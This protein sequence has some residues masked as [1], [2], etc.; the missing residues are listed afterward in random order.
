MAP[1]KA[2]I[3]MPLLPASTDDLLIDDAAQ[4]VL[5]RNFKVGESTPKKAHGD[6]I[7]N[8]WV[9]L[10]I[11]TINRDRLPVKTITLTLFGRASATGT[12]QQNQ[13]LSLLRAE[14]IG[15]VFEFEY[16]KQASG[17]AK[18]VKT[19]QKN[20]RPLGDKEARAAL[21]F[22]P[23]LVPPKKID[24]RQN[25]FRSVLTSFKMNHSITPEQTLI[26]CRMILDAQ[27]RVEPPSTT[28]FGQM[29]DQVVERIP[30][31]LRIGLQATF[32]VAKQVLI[33]GLTQ[34]L[35]TAEGAAI[36]A[37]ELL[38][39]VKGLEFIVPG[40]FACFFE[41][42]DIR[43]IN[44]KYLYTATSNKM[45]V[46]LLDVLK[47]LGGMMRVI[48]GV[49]GIV[50]KF[51]DALRA[52]AGKKIGLDDQQM[53]NLISTLVAL[54]TTCKQLHQDFKRLTGPD[55]AIRRAIGNDATDS[56]V[57]LVDG[58]GN[59]FITMSKFT[60]CTFEDVKFPDINTF[61]GDAR[62]FK[63]SIVLG[64]TEIEFD[65]AARQNI[66][67]LGFRGHCVFREPWTLS[68]TIGAVELTRGRLDPRI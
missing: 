12:A 21:G 17:L 65:F 2:T 42:K 36:T 48:K 6:F 52:G 60:K 14:A 53:R 59:R 44:K 30:L 15:D 9:P 33:D 56:L 43:G 50:E 24:D 23:N 57:R 37:P 27:F 13:E 41:F 34:M 32:N 55:G 26:E 46:G 61:A 29:I 39:I 8:F 19:I 18:E 66:S 64:T 38:I 63:T 10:T 51:I 20:V 25:D 45:D 16:F 31:L 4:T 40:D 7:A 54:G 35:K 62:T 58:D 5:F 3:G 1:G 68:L 22:N 11:E 67:L 28:L 47:F 49:P